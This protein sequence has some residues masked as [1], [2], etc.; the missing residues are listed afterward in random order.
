MH[1]AITEV[2]GG[3]M[4]YRHNGFDVTRPT[5]LF[6]HGIGE[7]GLCFLEAFHDS[8]LSDFNIVVPD[9][10]GFGKSSQAAGHDYAFSQQIVRVCGLLDGLGIVEF[11]LVG[12]SMG[13][14]IGTQ[15]CHQRSD[16]I[17]SFVNIE[18]DLTSGAPFIT[19]PA[20]QA[21]VGGRFEEWL[22][23]D[24]AQQQ[25]IDLCHQ[26]PSTV[27]YLASLNMCRSRA[28][29][30]SVYEI[31]KLNESLP[32]SNFTLIGKTYLELNT[33]RVFCWGIESLSGVAQAF[34]E[35]S[36]LINEAFDRSFHWVMLDQTARFY[37]FLSDFL[38]T[39]RKA[40]K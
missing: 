14:M 18:G 40:I 17:L 13:G 25:V 22:R 31:D 5:V 19:G 16:R 21:D 7:S 38:A 12:H 39:Q 2:D 20:I 26:W 3:Q 6:L 10:L 9:L 28:F 29:L 33:P 4:Y 37:S 8:W 35:D 15:F 1:E 11:H 24:F 30:A 36:A 27:R 23:D 32:G 34:L